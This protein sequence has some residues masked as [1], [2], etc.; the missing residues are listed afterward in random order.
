MYAWE[1]IQKV[2]DY[3]EENLAQDH[4][5]EELSKVA[6]LSPFYFQRLFARLVKRP[7]NAYT[8]MRRLARA[9]EALEDKSRRI[10]DIALDYG[11]NSHGHF[12]KSFKRAFGMTPEEYR[13]NPVHLNRIMKPDLLLGYTMI[14]EN[15]PLITDSIVIE[16]TRR[17]LDMPE[18]YIGVSNKVSVEQASF[19][20]STGIS[21]PGQIWEDFHGRKNCLTCFL[22]NGAE[23]GASMMSK[24]NDGTFIYFA[25]A[26]A[27][28]NAPVPNGLTIWELPAGEY[29]V[30]QF[31][32][33]SFAE[34]RASA[35][36]KA[37]KYLLETW[38]PGHHLQIQ[39]FSAEKY[40][41]VTA[42]PAS[43]EIWV[44]L[45]SATE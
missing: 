3:I 28:S 21:G 20:E 14:D 25:G 10:L 34:L 17:K 6:A 16:I 33:E 39:P 27:N 15:V 41:S 11:F 38:L 32:A 18:T 24:E 5:P 8:K 37:L 7:V 22:P 12:T 36:D 35:I 19:G 43:M 30:C 40:T 1:A 9:C 45:I 29:A 44:L 26:A 31:E 42:S 2:L 23:L 4:S 13:N